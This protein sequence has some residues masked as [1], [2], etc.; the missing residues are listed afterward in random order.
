[1]E[2]IG[3]PSFEKREMEPGHVPSTVMPEIWDVFIMLG[4]VGAMI[5]AYM[6]AARLFPI[7]NFWEQRELQLYDQGHVRNHRGFVR[8]MGKSE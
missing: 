2:G 6:L 8:V 3:N 7:M 4:A 1:M 5:L